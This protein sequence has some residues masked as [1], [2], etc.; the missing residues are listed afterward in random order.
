MLR[1]AAAAAHAR[2]MCARYWAS[3]LQFYTATQ[4]FI[5]FGCNLNIFNKHSVSMYNSS[6]S[7]ECKNAR[8]H[9]EKARTKRLLNETQRRGNNTCK[10]V[11]GREHEKKL[12]NK[13]AETQ[14]NNPVKNAWQRTVVKLGFCSASIM[15]YFTADQRSHRQLETL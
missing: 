8:R 10:S 14:K 2:I 6:S 12:P 7:P 4:R 11:A 15:F 5:F 9:D 13:G 1:R 3:L